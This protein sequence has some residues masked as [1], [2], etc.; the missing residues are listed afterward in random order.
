MK[1]SVITV[2]VFVMFSMTVFA[3][4]GG[5]Q[6]QSTI[7]TDPNVPITLTVWC[8]DPNFNIFAM[9]EAAKIYNRDKP[10]VKI[11]IV[12]T[13]WADVQQK[14]ITALGA[15]ETSSLPDILLMQDNT[16][17][18]NLITYPNAFL[19]VSDKI[20]I[21]QFAKFKTGYGN[22][23]GKYYGVPFDNGAAA[24]FLRRDIVEQAGLKVEDFNNITWERF[25]ELGKI[26]KQRTGVTMIS[27]HANGRE[28]INITLQSAGTWFFDTQGKPFINSNQV[29][30][31]AIELYIEMVNSGVVLPTT[32]RDDLNAAFN[33]GKVASVIEG[34]WTIASIT[35]E[36]SQKGKWAAVNVPRFGTI[37]SATNYSSN[38]GSGW[39]VLSNSKNPDVAIDFLAKTFAGSKELYDIILPSSGAITTWLPAADSA[40]YSQSSEYF[41]G[42]KIY[43]DLV[44]FAGKVPQVKYGVFNDEARAEVVKA[45]AAIM[46]GAPIQK[47]LDEAQRNV[48]FIINQ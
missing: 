22:M 12:E 11:N 23:N 18:K 44:S 32:T 26:V 15:N 1:K 6:S 20:D 5:Q 45:L 3:G 9:N 8:W 17:Q 37:G 16:I 46:Q 10:N 31:Q 28:F 48:E 29:L 4:G 21:N 14:L 34:C 36:T 41:G 33:T 40:V 47:A 39:M 24:T 7:P 30:K 38:G 2:L 27:F 42:Q 19:P 13:P 25:I 43:T 35:A